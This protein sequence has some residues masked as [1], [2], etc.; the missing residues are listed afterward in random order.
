MVGSRDERQRENKGEIEIERLR[1][2]VR[3]RLRD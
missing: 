2:G 3:E 1:A